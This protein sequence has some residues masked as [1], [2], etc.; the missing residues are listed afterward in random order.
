[1]KLLFAALALSAAGSACA[2][3]IH[4]PPETAT[5]KASELPGYQLVQRNCMTCHAAQYASSQPPASPRAYWEATVKKMKKPFGAQFDDADMPAMVDYLVKTY[6][7]ERGAAAPAAAVARPAAA[8]AAVP[9][10]SGKDAK[11][12]LAANGCMA[13]HALDQKVVG[14]GF[15]EVAARY[16]GKDGVAAVAANIRSGGAGKWGP[17]PMP[18]FSQ[19]SVADAAALAKYVLSR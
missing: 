17:V 16:K 4:L 7:A 3:E 14:P 5:Y 1:M 19:L 10:A 12:L 11:T 18:P 13:C 2:L 15:A 9:A 6:G 8:A